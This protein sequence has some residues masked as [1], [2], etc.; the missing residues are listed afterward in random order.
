MNNHCAQRLLPLALC[1]LLTLLGFVPQQVRAEPRHTYFKDAIAHSETIAVVTLLDLPSSTSVFAKI[2]PKKVATLNVMRVLKGRVQA[3]K[4]DVRFEDYPDR[5][6]GEFVAFIDKA[7]V[8]RFTADPINSR[9]VDSDVLT[10]H[11][12]NDWNAHFVTPGF[13]TLKQLSA[14]LKDGSL[15]YSFRGPI[16]FPQ[17]GKPS[18]KPSALVIGGTYDAVRDSARVTGLNKLAGIPPRLTIFAGSDHRGE[19]HFTLE[20]SGSGMPRRLELLGKVE[21]VDKATDDFIVRFAVTSINA[22]T[23]KSLEEYLADGRRG[24]LYYAFRLNCTPIKGESKRRDLVL[25]LEKESGTIGDLEGWD[26]TPL[27]IVATSYNGPSLR[28]EQLLREPPRPISSLSA[29]DWVLR[30]VVPTHSNDILVLAFDLGKPPEGKDTLRWRFQPELLY[31]LYNAPVRGRLQIDDGKSLRTI[32]T[33]SVT[34]E[35]VKFGHFEAPL[36]PIVP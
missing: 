14:Y 25:T 5:P 15:V 24:H 29:D 12:F 4:L 34:L 9:K 26:D 28:S 27:E 2:N 6:G 30:M 32:A 13:L 22:L 17:E 1:G 33:F 10:I 18:W 23:Q 11:G 7:G 21:G 19:A 36:P 16:W 8:W 3:G 20:Y 35:A 31:R